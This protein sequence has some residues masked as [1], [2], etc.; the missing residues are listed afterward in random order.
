MENLSKE[1]IGREL[2]SK[3]WRLSASNG[4]LWHYLVSEANNGTPYRFAACGRM[5][6]PEYRYP[7]F[8]TIM[9]PLDVGSEK[10]CPRCV[11]VLS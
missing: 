3:Y 5:I 7:E 10:A 8:T 9:Q 4:K 6:P 11:K 2:P 1:I